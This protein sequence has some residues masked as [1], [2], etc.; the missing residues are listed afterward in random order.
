[1]NLQNPNK[2]PFMRQ[3]F[4]LV[5]NLK[6][7]FLK[8]GISELKLYVTIVFVEQSFL[9]CVRNIHKLCWTKLNNVEVCSFLKVYNF[10]CHFLIRCEFQQSADVYFFCCCRVVA[11]QIPWKGEV[12][13]MPIKA[14]TQL[15]LMYWKLLLRSLL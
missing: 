2:I 6:S 15:Y 10:S 13:I 9:K 14:M 7:S 5:Y 4:Y 3:L 1:M 8:C 12:Q 11:A